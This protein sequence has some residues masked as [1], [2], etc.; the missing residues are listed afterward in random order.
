VMVHLVPDEGVDDGPVLAT[1]T[2]DMCAGDTLADLEA[3]VH[4]AEHELLVSTLG[5]LTAR[6][7][8]P[9]ER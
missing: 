2:V 9:Q 7:P 1:A 5:W 8:T 4:A 3:R 6:T